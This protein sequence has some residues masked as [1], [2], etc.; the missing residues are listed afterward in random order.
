MLWLQL[1]LLAYDTSFVP[2]RAKRANAGKFDIFMIDPSIRHALPKRQ[3]DVDLSTVPQDAA[4]V[5][6]SAVSPIRPMLQDAQTTTVLTGRLRFPL[7][8][9]NER[10]AL[11]D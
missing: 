10:Q 2:S 3:P 4:S 1:E 6:K 8:G 9:F 11:P 7:D 5:P